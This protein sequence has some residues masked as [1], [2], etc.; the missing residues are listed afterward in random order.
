MATRVVRVIQR[1]PIKPGPE[2]GADIGVIYA[3]TILALEV[4]KES[5]HDGWCHIVGPNPPIGADGKYLKTGKEGWIE[6]AHVVDANKEKSII[7]IEIDWN[8]KSWNAREG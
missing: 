1:S 6:D 8:N 5:P 3:G 4:S 7:S 2:G